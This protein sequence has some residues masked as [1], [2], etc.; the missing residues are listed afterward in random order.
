MN[1][2]VDDAPAAADVPLTKLFAECH[3]ADPLA[4]YLDQLRDWVMTYLVTPHPRLGR[5]GAVCPFTATSVKKGL[6]WAGAAR[7]P[8][9][10]AGDIEKIV[11]DVVPV[12]QGLPPAT[13]P[14]T[15]LKTILVL[16]PTVADYRLIDEA[17]RHL[18]EVC[19]PRGIMIGQFYPDCD[20]PG[21]RNPDFRP[22]RSPIPLLAIRHMVSSDL[23]FLTAR[24]DWIA[25]YLKKFGSAAPDAARTALA[26]GPGTRAAC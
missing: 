1:E 3:P 5:E 10:T 14:N 15:L 6:F 7:Q 20:E 13:G 2:F 9:L 26:A 8:G 18:K 21:I 24:A 12:F 16:F 23:P 4:P 17:Q 11:A 22:L 19:V 25:E